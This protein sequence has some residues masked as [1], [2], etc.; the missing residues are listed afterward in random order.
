MENK[1]NEK[2]NSE[3]R[4]GHMKKLLNKYG[5]AVAL[6]VCAA[7][8]AGTWLL[9][10]GNLLGTKPTPAPNPT[11]TKS[12][13]S[14]AD[15]S[16]SLYDINKAQNPA[17]SVVPAAPKLMP[18]LVKP[19]KGNI[20]KKFANESLVYMKTLNQ[21][22]T[23]A[24]VDI[25][26]KVGDDV[27]SALKGTVDS[28]YNDPS[29]GN[30]VKIKSDGDVVCVYAGLVNKTT[31]KKGDAIEAGELIG[32]LGNT[33]A[34]EAMEDQHLHFEVWVKS[35]PQNPEPFFITK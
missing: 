33:A 34:F 31:V 35:V 7:I 10:D 1:N 13:P 20:T 29:L 26:G 24:G 30:C 11:A 9:T 5:I 6:F 15:Y 28:T 17:P 16:Q 3:G 4:R 8:V 23:H 14:G 27:V 2:K 21:W 22:S 19:V 32:Q 25:S 18:D 12:A